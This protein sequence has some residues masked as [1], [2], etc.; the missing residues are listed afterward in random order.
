MDY[1]Q[2]AV[3][4]YLQ[5]DRA[6]FINT[7]FFLVHKQR[8]N[9]PGPSEW[10][11]DILAVNLRDK[12]AYLCEISY[13]AKLAALEKRLNEWS[14]NWPLVKSTVQHQAHV[15]TDWT[16]QVLVFVPPK[17][18]DRFGARLPPF[19]PEARIESLEKVLPWDYNRWPRR[20]PELT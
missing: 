1:F 16:I 5:R 11:A 20:F 10:L 4:E 17:E 8:A 12:C 15:P 9:D 7:E 13:A 2:S 14:E 6:T 19:E 3:A 18:I